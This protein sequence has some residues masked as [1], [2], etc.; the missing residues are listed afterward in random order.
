MSTTPPVI[1]F[2]TRTDPSDPGS[3]KKDTDTG[4]SIVSTTTPLDFGIINADQDVWSAVRVF[5]GYLADLGGN[6]TVSAMKFYIDGIF[7]NQAKIQSYDKITATWEAP[8]SQGTQQSGNSPS[9]TT[10]SNAKQVLKDDGVS[11]S[12]N[13]INQFTQFIF[14]QLFVQ[15]GAPVGAHV[16]SEGKGRLKLAFNYS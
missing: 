16:T 5:W 9:A 1:R 7:D 2:V 13:A 11:Q 12:L 8:G 6:S 10:Y 15:A 4:N 3:N 14:C